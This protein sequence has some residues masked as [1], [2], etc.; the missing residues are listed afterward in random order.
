[1]SFSGVIRLLTYFSDRSDKGNEDVATLL[2]QMSELS[3]YICQ[4]WQVNIDGLEVLALEAKNYQKRRENQPFD[5]FLTPKSLSITQ[6]AQ[7]RRANTAEAYDLWEIEKK[8]D[9]KGRLE[10]SQ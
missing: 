6:I 1:M 4:V 9:S 8:I 3:T 10:R 5:E 7:A 2:E